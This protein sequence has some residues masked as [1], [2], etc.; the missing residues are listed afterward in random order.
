[1]WCIILSLL[2]GKSFIEINIF[3]LV[4]AFFFFFFYQQCR[5]NPTVSRPKHSFHIVQW[6]LS[7]PLCSYDQEHFSLFFSVFSFSS[8]QLPCNSM[9]KHYKPFDSHYCCVT[10]TLF[11]QIQRGIGCQLLSVFFSFQFFFFFFYPP[12]FFKFD[13]GFEAGA[14]LRSWRESACQGKSRL[15]GEKLPRDHSTFAASWLRDET[16]QNKET[17]SGKTHTYIM[18]LMINSDD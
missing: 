8:P 17:D 6:F 7:Q 4:T 18:K 2:Y 12:F 5:H 1:M 9:V 11:W 13:F 16:G 3:S 10:V 14:Q 15:H